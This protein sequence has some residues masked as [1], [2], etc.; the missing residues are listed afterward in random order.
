MIAVVGCSP[1]ADGGAAVE[2]AA[3]AIGVA[4][5]AEPPALVGGRYVVAATGNEVRYRVREQLIG[6]DVPNDAIGKSAQI[7]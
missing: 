1:T 4:S 3:G 6:F 7:R 5:L 2:S